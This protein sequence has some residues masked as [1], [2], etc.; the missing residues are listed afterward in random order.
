MLQS[1]SFG[2]SHGGISGASSIGAHF[3]LL[4]LVQRVEATPADFAAGLIQNV[5]IPHNALAQ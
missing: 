4:G 2:F 5:V 1:A 3:L